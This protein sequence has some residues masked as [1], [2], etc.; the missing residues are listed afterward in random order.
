MTDCRP[1]RFVLC[2]VCSKPH[3]SQARRDGMYCVDCYKSIILTYPP[4]KG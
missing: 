2:C 4:Q 3:A 1:T